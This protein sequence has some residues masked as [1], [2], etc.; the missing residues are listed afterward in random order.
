MISGN[1]FKNVT[2]SNLQS[3]KCDSTKS[4]WVHNV[5]DVSVSAEST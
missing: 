4:R 2:V 3:R 5:S 1:I